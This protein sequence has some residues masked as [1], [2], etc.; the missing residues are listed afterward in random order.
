MP[1]SDLVSVHCVPGKG[2]VSFWRAVSSR[3]LQ[4]LKVLAGVSG[5]QILVQCSAALSGLLLVHVLGKRQFGSYAIAASLF[6]TFNVLTDCGIGTGLNALGGRA[7]SDPAT[8]GGLVATALRFRGRLACVGLPVG[9]GLG[10][11][12]LR[13]NHVG[14]AE[15]L[16]LVLAAAIGIW[17]IATTNTYAVV[18]RLVR[19]YFDVQ[20][21]ELRTALVRLALL[22]SMSLLCIN[23]I[24]AALASSVSVT[25]QALGM[26]RSAHTIFPAHAAPVPGLESELARFVRQQWFSTG[27]FAFQGQITLWL[28]ALFGDVD[29]V[30]EVGALGRLA[31]AFGF[32]TSLLSAI[33]T[34][35]LARCDSVNRLRRLFAVMLLAYVLFAGLL[36]AAGFAFPHQVL[37]ILGAKYAGLASELPI[38]IGTSVV[39]G[40]TG[41]LYALASARGW[42]WKAWMSPLV[43]IAL[44]TVLLRWLDL[45]QVRG[46]LMF[47]LLSSSPVL[48]SVACM[49]GRGF[50]VRQNPRHTGCLP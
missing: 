32:M 2:A 25:F 1:V 30:A 22:G 5:L 47:G 3:R 39:W 12:L 35:T 41:V 20:R 15:S 28:I 17:G 36:L 27:F 13:Q 29:K 21:L 9:A 45:S 7:C 31:V 46:V 50:V 34:P 19:K 44:Q 40:L 14:W 10:L 11:L 37:W 33:A 48:F 38:V 49:V 26:R 16:A 42:I 43:T 24:M 8:L 4:Q 6:S 23:A 18:L